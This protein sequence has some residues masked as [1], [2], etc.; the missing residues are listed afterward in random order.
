MNASSIRNSWNIFFLR[1][2][3]TMYEV[4]FLPMMMLMHHHKAKFSSYWILSHTDGMGQKCRYTGMHQRVGCC[5]FSCC[6]NVHLFSMHEV[7]EN[8]EIIQHISLIER[9]QHWFCVRDH[10]TQINPIN[11]DCLFIYK[12]DGISWYWFWTLEFLL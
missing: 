5:C 2:T 11:D 9:A 7:Y 6:L 3:L 4:L 1:C 12:L 10:I 8:K